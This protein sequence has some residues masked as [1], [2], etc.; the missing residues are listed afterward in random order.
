MKILLDTDVLLDVALSRQPYAVD[1]GTTLDW[2]EAH[3]GSAAVAW[4]TLA[5]IAYLLKGGARQFLEDLLS[6]VVVAEISTEA[7]RQALR[8][9]MTD[10][11][12]AF[13]AVSALEFKA[14]YVVTRNIRDY[15]RSP[16]RAVS[17]T[18]V[19]KLLSD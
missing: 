17:P 11:E 4:H 15:Q 13:Q 12:D 1:S 8:L 9:P 14:D 10:L 3:P 19:V 16:V 2:A 7:A 6:F 5:N 18:Q